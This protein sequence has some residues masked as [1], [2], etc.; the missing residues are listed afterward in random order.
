MIIQS[1]LLKSIVNIIVLIPHNIRK[2]IFCA[3]LKAKGR[4]L[5]IAFPCKFEGK[6]NIEIGDDVSIAAFVH[7]WGHGGVSIGDRVLIATHVAITS[8]T[9][10]YTYQNMRS[11]PIIAKPV[12]IEND[13]WIGSNAVIMPGVTIGTGAVVG[14][15]AVVT[16]DVP[17]YSIVAG[18]P[19][20]VMKYR[21]IIHR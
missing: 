11:A 9:H 5:S 13:V 4:N 20:K 19:A 14:A 6:Q 2:S 10:D 17:R 1:R 7:V 12:V 3:G 18:I 21:E 8:L 15:G 16:K